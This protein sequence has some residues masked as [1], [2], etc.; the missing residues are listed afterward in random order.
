MSNRLALSLAVVGIVAGVLAHRWLSPA[1]S[2]Q[3][4]AK[5]PPPSR[6]ALATPSSTMP[7]PAPSAAPHK[8]LPRR[9]Q[10]ALHD[11]E[12]TQSA[13]GTPLTPEQKE[14]LQQLARAWATA[15]ARAQADDDN[16]AQREAAPSDDKGD[17]D[18]AAADK[19][20]APDAQ[21]IRAAVRS[22]LPD[23]QACY[24]PWAQLNK[25]DG[26]PDT[27]GGRIVTHFAILAPKANDAGVVDEDAEAQ[28]GDVGIKLGGLGNAFLEGCVADVMKT[29]HFTPPPGGKIEV[30]YPLVFSTSD[31]DKTP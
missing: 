14:A 27:F 19:P 7:T 9:Q 4:T 23:L 25:D 26:D 31:D 20:F 2:A 8:P 22:K 5:P 28:V 17:D 30:N 12:R 16:D 15:S 10:Q 21:G 13:S 11:A 3:S 18:A 24:D 6:S 1:R 29:L